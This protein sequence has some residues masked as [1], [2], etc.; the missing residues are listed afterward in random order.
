MHYIAPT[1]LSK[2]WDTIEERVQGHLFPRIFE[3]HYVLSI[4]RD[5][6]GIF[7]VREHVLT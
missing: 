6:L 2:S 4:P 1:G 5:A 3:C 7:S